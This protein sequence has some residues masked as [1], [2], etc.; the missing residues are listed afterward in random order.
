MGIILCPAPYKAPS[1]RGLAWNKNKE[2]LD[3]N[4]VEG[5]ST[6]VDSTDDENYPSNNQKDY[7]SKDNEPHPS[8]VSNPVSK[9]KLA[10]LNDKYRSVS[11]NFIL[12]ESS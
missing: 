5:L 10:K 11:K 3:S 2:R 1:S 6:D 12:G 9:A 7:P 4:L 8:N